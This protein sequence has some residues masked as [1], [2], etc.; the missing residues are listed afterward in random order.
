MKKTTLRYAFMIAGIIG[1]ICVIAL[2]VPHPAAAQSADPD[3]AQLEEQ[4]GSEDRPDGKKPGRR[5]RLKGGA[6][7]M[8]ALD[9]DRDGQLSAEEIENATN[10][11][12]TLDKNGDGILGRDELRPPRGAR[13]GQ[14]N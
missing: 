13:S 3:P 2:T 1:F 11:L 9:T 4:S 10:I 12:K 8:R 6:P 5:S 14:Q 7:L